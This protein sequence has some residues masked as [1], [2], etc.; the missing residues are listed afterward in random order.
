VG[1]LP[2]GSGEVEVAAVCR[3]LPKDTTLSFMPWQGLSFAEV[4]QGLAALG[5]LHPAAQS[6]AESWPSSPVPVKSE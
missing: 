4:K 3:A 2:P 6:E 5:R 1:A